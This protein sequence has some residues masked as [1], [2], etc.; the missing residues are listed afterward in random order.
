MAHNFQRSLAFS[1]ND[2]FLSVAPAYLAD[3]FY[4][5]PANIEL[6]RN[7]E[8]DKH[9]GDFEIHT[10]CG[11]IYI[12]YKL[13]RYE[14]RND[15]CI[16]IVS[17]SARN[18]LRSVEDISA[19]VQQS[20]GWSIDKCKRSDYI[21]YAWPYDNNSFLVRMYDFVALRLESIARWSEW[22]RAYGL[23]VIPNRSR[24]DRNKRFYTYCVFV[25]VGDVRAPSFPETTL[26]PNRTQ[27]E[28][29]N[30]LH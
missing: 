10:A 13:R 11:P 14:F 17:V 5:N 7:D 30:E 29:P 23:Q 3:T 24:F 16:E 2:A 9:G 27:Q 18:D 21:L 15:I 6:H 1:Y 8:L 22:I 4:T 25:P 19:A 26:N 28:V 12:D 20:P